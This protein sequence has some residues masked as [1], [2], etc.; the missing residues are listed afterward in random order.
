[1]KQ[2]TQL[3][4][5]ILFFACN[6]QDNENTVDKNTQNTTVDTSGNATSSGKTQSDAIWVYR[7]D[8]ILN[9]YK[10]VKLR[11]VLPDTLTAGM[12]C[13]ILNA[14]WPDVQAKVI[15]TSKDTIFIAIPQ[16]DY[17]TQQMGSTGAQEYMVTAT[18]S[19]TELKGIK[20]VS[21]DFA[22]GD[23]A[24]PGVY[25]RSTWDMRLQ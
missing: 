3:F 23:H 25:D 4:L 6:T 2:V 16:S 11:A 15:K 21:F 13:S 7:F 12:I 1:M 14:T 20:Y 18:F 10:P 24:V 22:E 17:L 19:F 5:L 9:D 8:S